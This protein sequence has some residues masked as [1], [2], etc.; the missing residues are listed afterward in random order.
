MVN[1]DVSNKVLEKIKKLKVMADQS[2]SINEAGVAASLMSEILLKYNLQ[3][4]DIDFATE[5]SSEYI[6]EARDTQMDGP[7]YEDPHWRVTLLGNIAKHNFCKVL[8]AY[9]SAKYQRDASYT[10]SEH[11]LTYIV[12]EKHNIEIVDYI[13]TYL[14]KVLEKVALKMWIEYTRTTIGKKEKEDKWRESFFAGANSVL[15]QRLYDMKQKVSQTNENSMALVI[16]KDKDLENAFWDFFPHLHPKVNLR[17]YVP[18][19]YVCTKYRRPRGRPSTKSY[20]NNAA[21]ETGEKMAAVIPIHQGVRSGEAKSTGFK[22]L[23]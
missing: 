7:F 11:E 15:N 10:P 12:G 19:P 4:D 2:A 18:S 3:L 22:K 16:V 9:Y 20:Y 17:K 5:R 6:K 8:G 13:Y 21:Y 1:Q 14:R 23:V